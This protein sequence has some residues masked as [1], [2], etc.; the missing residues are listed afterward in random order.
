M[1]FAFL[2]KG[3]IEQEKERER[4]EAREWFESLNTGIQRQQDYEIDRLI[5]IKFQMIS[6][7]YANP[8][9]IEV[10]VKY[11]KSMNA[12]DVNQ[13]CGHLKYF[14]KIY[15]NERKSQSKFYDAQYKNVHKKPKKKIEIGSLFGC[16]SFFIR[17]KPIF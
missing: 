15:N 12:Q 8:K 10:A 14:E 4:A 3:D 2:Y 9:F 6:H 13:F 11:A 16:F 1:F 17:I 7:Q 5:N